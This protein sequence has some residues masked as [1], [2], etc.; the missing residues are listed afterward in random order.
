[1]SNFIH[2]SAAIM[3]LSGK[4]VP[5]GTG[6]GFL[7]NNYSNNLVF[8][9]VLLSSLANTLYFWIIV[10][11]AITSYISRDMIQKKQIN[12]VSNKKSVFNLAT[13][14]LIVASIYL[15]L[16]YY[17]I[18]FCSLMIHMI[19]TKM[20]FADF[21]MLTTFRFA[22]FN[23]LAMLSFIWI[24]SSISMYVKSTQYT[25]LISFIIF[26]AGGFYELM[27]LFKHHTGLIP[28]IIS[29]INPFV[30]TMYFSSLNQT[31]NVSSLLFF[32]LFSIICS[33]LLIKIMETKKD[34]I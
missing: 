24:A 33:L 22:S 15:S 19:Y 17:I 34:Y 2:V 30:Y 1:M 18:I 21:K 29:K 31:N 27:K 28:M 11:M 8:D 3:A 26:F 9:E 25:H 23:L 7:F 14:K 12:A 4:N 32:T 13:S 5:L 20:P 6:I 16:L 10:L